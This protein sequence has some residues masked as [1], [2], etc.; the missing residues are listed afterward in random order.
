M[1]GKTSRY[2]IILRDTI[3]RRGT[4]PKFAYYYAN[5]NRRISE[6]TR[7]DV[8]K[9]YIPHTWDE[10]EIYLG[11]PKLIA[12]G[13]LKDQ[14]RYLYQKEFTDNQSNKKYAR[15]L[16]FGK[17]LPTIKKDIVKHLTSDSPSRTKVIATALWILTM[18]YIR[19][20]NEKYLK[21]N[22]THGLLTL[23]KKHIQFRGDNI[24]LDFIGKK[25]VQNK[26]DVCIPSAD[27]KKWLQYLYNN[28]KPFLFHHDGHRI[29]AND[30]NGYI[31]ENYGPF[32]AKDF[33]TWGANIEFLK[34]LRKLDAK[35]MLTKRDVQKAAKDTVESVSNKL[36]NTISVCKSNYICKEIFDEFQDNPE[37]F[38]KKL[39]RN[40]S[41]HNYLLI[42]LK[43]LDH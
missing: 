17:E 32:T 22:N 19:V 43:K 5:T 12:T 24:C 3:S 26:Y 30:L 25:S 2:T 28:S 18:S 33:R 38:L 1:D 27:L 7:K 23:Q 6:K 15:L 39:K 42:L 29:T 16:K 40:K 31:Q 10:V 20:G 13:M 21:E 8:E 36:N 14:L 35:Q 9:T 41:D 4:K 37:D 34:E 11:H